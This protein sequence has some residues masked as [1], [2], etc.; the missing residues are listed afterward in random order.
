MSEDKQERYSFSKLNAFHTCPYG[1]WE[2]YVNHKPGIGNAFSSFGT[3]VH[4]LMERYAKGEAEIWELPELYEWEF[5]AAVPEEFPPNKYVVLRDTYYQQG[6][7]FLQHFQGYDKYKILGVEKSFTLPVKDWSFMGIIDLVF[8]DEQ[9][10]FVIR[11][12]KSKA[13]F[14]NAREQKEYARQLYLYSLEVKQEFGKYPDELQFLMFRTQSL[15]RIPFDERALNEA[16]QWADDT[17]HEIREAISY[18]PTCNDFYGNCL[19]NHREYCPF[20]IEAG[21]NKRK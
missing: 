2:R 11:D 21:G 8:T 20:K 18:P 13:G 16:V 19:C 7:R 10:R 6:L 15:V 3:L 14:K 1:W 12:Y 17:V 4:S 9:G 5:A